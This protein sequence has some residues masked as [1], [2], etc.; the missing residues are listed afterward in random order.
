MALLRLYAATVAPPAPA[1]ASVPVQLLE[2]CCAAFHDGSCKYEAWNWLKQG[3]M[4]DMRD[5]YTGA[6]LRHVHHFVGGEDVARDSG[7]S[8][9]G[10]AAACAAILGHHLDITPEYGSVHW[11]PTDDVVDLTDE[12]VR[13]AH[14]FADPSVDPR[15]DGAEL[16]RV[17]RCLGEIA[18]H[19]NVGYTEPASVRAKRDSSAKER[20]IRAAQPAVNGTCFMPDGAEIDTGFKLTPSG[21]KP[22]TPGAVELLRSADKAVVEGAV[23]K[24]RRGLPTLVV[25]RALPVGQHGNTLHVVRPRTAL[26]GA[27]YTEAVYECSLSP[28]ELEWWRSE[29]LP[30][31]G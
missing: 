25:S 16:A 18:R 8:H 22:A 13:A 27:R 15:D 5:T 7:V 23:I 24:D 28:D 17:V 11:E 12:L 26:T 31:L 6:L 4:V 14:A 19:E 3:C 21:W 29:V 20:L 1:F 9:I 10:H 30:R 2:A